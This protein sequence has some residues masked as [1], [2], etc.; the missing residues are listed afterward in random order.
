[1]PRPLRVCA[2][3]Q[4]PTTT[5]NT[6]CDTHQRTHLRHLSARRPTT[7]QR[8]YG[9]NHQKNAAQQIRTQPWCAW[10]GDGPTETAARGDHLAGDHIIPLAHGGTNDPTNYQ[11]LCGRCNSSKRDRTSPPPGGDPDPHDTPDLRA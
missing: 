6:R 11:T 4:C 8:G 2:E 7:T 5:R 1:M 3:P 10:C 9:T